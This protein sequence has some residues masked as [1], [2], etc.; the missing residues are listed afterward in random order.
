MREILELKKKKKSKEK[1]N[2]KKLEMKIALDLRELMDFVL[3]C[4]LSGSAVSQRKKK[5]EVQSVKKNWQM[6][7]K[8][9]RRVKSS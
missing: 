9:E 1:K 5:Q 6:E 7:R 8:E 3:D 2:Q 4:L